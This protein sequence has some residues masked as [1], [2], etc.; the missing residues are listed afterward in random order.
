MGAR[1]REV[2]YCKLQPGWVVH[3][4]ELSV[5]HWAAVP[6]HAV[7]AQ[8]ALEQVFVLVIDS[9]AVGVPVHEVPLQLQPAD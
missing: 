2:D 6:M 4:T 1:P 8:P 3:S 7:Q 5:E 9:H